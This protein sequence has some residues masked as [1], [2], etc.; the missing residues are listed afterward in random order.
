MHD[1]LMVP[2]AKVL[3]PYG[4]LSFCGIGPF[5]R[6]FWKTDPMVSFP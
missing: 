2:S 5:T 3:C 4:V 6:K 1:K